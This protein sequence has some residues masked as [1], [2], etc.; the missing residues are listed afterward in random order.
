MSTRRKPLI[1]IRLLV[2]RGHAYCPSSAP[3]RPVEHAYCPSTMPLATRRAA[4]LALCQAS[5]AS[6]SCLGVVACQA[7]RPP[8]LDVE[9]GATVIDLGYMVCDQSHLV[10]MG[11]AFLAG[12]PIAP[13]YCGR[14]FPMRWGLIVR[15]VGAAFAG[16]VPQSGSGRPL[17]CGLNGPELAHGESAQGARYFLSGLIR[18]RMRGIS[19]YSESYPVPDRYQ[20]LR[21]SPAACRHRLAC[22][23]GVTARLGNM[24]LGIGC[25]GNSRFL[26]HVSML[27]M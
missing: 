19:N 26:S 6:S 1:C 15:F 7:D 12:V 2:W 22:A 10:T 11:A 25:A 21:R 20:S 24:I 14:P 5:G 23:R 8:I 16:Q 4:R 9:R 13:L 17:Q 27:K 3:L 18:S